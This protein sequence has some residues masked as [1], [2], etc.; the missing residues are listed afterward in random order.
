MEPMPRTMVQKMTGG[1]HHLDELDEAVT[2]RLEGL[3]NLGEHQA[4][5]GAEHYGQDDRDVQI[6][7]LVEPPLASTFGG[8]CRLSSLRGHGI[9][10]LDTV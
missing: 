6:V 7:R 5:H 1:N 8:Y 9:L 3:A 4:D 2:E 10:L